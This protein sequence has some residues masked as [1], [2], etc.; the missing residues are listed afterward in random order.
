LRE[1]V[2]SVEPNAAYRA[3]AAWRV[4]TL[5]RGRQFTLATQNIDDLHER[6]SSPQVAHLHGGLYS[7]C[8]M[9]PGCTYGQRHDTVPYSSAPPCPQCGGRLRPAVVLFGERL[10]VDAEHEARVA[11]RSCDLFLAVGTSATVSSAL[12]LLRYANDVGARTVCIDPAPA[13]NERFGL[14]VQ[15]R[16]ELVLDKLVGHLDN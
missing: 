8:C 2:A 3:V 5:Q 4:A 13:V 7:T 16:A 11:V 10:D 1:R 15:D 12:A 14:H 6:A 9:S